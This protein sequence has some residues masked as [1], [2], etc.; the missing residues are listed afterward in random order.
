MKTYIPLLFLFISCSNYSEQKVIDRKNSSI[1]T[2]VDSLRVNIF[3][4]MSRI[5]QTKDS[6][7][8]YKNIQLDSLLKYVDIYKDSADKIEEIRKKFTTIHATNTTTIDSLSIIKKENKE[9]KSELNKS[10]LMYSVANSNVISAK[11]ETENLKKKFNNPT[12]VGVSIKYYGFKKRFLKEPLRYETNVAKDIR[13]MIVQF[14]VPAND[15]IE[16]KTYSFG[17][18]IPGILNKSLIIKLSGEEINIEPVTFEI[19]DV[20]KPGNYNFT[21]LCLD[22]IVYTCKFTLK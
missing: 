14:I 20:L 21:I 9:I 18:V 3:A 15:L 4:E 11:K 10:K 22:K 1:T 17:M 2:I 7:L 19:Y 8:M 12:V 16:K 6:S 5:V 13:R